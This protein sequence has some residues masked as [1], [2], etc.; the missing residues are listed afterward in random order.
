MGEES[1]RA[2][3]DKKPIERLLAAIALMLLTVWSVCLGFA[4]LRGPVSTEGFARFVHRVPR[5]AAA[6]IALIVA[7]PYLAFVF[8]GGTPAR[9]ERSR[10]LVERVVAPFVAVLAAVSVWAIATPVPRFAFDVWE[11]RL[12]TTA[13]GVP[14]LAVGALL[15]AVGFAVSF[16][17]T[18]H[19]LALARGAADS[20]RVALLATIAALLALVTPASATIYL[21]TGT[22]LLPVGEPDDLFAPAFE[23]IPCPP[24]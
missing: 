8:R 19:R 17:L 2:V 14:W 13:G 7:T 20:R 12:S 5:V 16:G 10:I 15:V 1:P 9:P 3:P 22:R 23:A 18:T 11:R 24:K 6:V 21:A 4:L